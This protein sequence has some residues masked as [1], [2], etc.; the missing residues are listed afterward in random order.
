MSKFTQ[1]D[2]Y[3]C[4]ELGVEFECSKPTDTAWSFIQGKC[5]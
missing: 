5:I 1:Y 3:L 2:A 4:E